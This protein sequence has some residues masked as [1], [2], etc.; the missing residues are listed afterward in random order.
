MLAHWQRRLARPQ[1]PQPRQ[2]LRQIVPRA[3]LQPQAAPLGHVHVVDPP[4]QV[5][6]LEKSAAARQKPRQAEDGF[7]ARQPKTFVPALGF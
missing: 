1:G 6:V 5:Q 7:A 3:R 2:A 4:E